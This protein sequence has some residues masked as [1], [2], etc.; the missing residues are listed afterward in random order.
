MGFEV[1]QLLVSIGI[2]PGLEV[3]F[4]LLFV[5]LFSHFFAQIWGKFHI[6]P[7]EKHSRFTTGVPKQLTNQ[8]KLYEKKISSPLQR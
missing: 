1:A 5:T 4:V 3:L 6:S 8:L 7:K 2:S